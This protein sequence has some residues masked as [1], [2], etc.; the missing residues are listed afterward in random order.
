[1]TILLEAM[2]LYND[3]YRVRKAQAG[4]AGA[5]LILTLQ[6]EEDSYQQEQDILCEKIRLC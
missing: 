2:F 1:M 5:K 4:L 6:G 3:L